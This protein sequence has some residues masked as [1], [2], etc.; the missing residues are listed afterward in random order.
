MREANRAAAAMPAAEDSIS[1]GCTV[2]SMDSAGR[3]FQDMANVPGVAVLDVHNGTVLSFEGVLEDLG[4]AGAVIRGTSFA[5]SKAS[6]R[7]SVEVCVPEVLNLSGSRYEIIE[8]TRNMGG[9][10]FAYGVNM[11]GVVLGRSSS[12]QS[13]SSHQYWK[14]T[15]VEG[16]LYGSVAASYPSAALSDASFVA[17]VAEPSART[18]QPLLLNDESTRLLAVPDGMDEPNLACINRHGQ[19]GG[20]VAVNKDDTDGHRAKPVVWFPDGRVS[21]LQNL[22]GSG[23]GRVVSLNDHGVRSYIAIR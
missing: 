19:V 15:E 9:D 20:Q 14:W 8:I 12:P 21:I 13:P 3:G 18:F 6:A 7:G 22:L 10:S 17:L 23:S 2:V 4:I 16:L 11:N 1:E 5:S